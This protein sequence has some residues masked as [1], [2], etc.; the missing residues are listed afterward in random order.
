M[1]NF[2]IHKSTLDHG[3]GRYY[4]T[5]ECSKEERA[6]ISQT[7]LLNS[8]CAQESYFV[9]KVVRYTTQLN[10]ML[11]FRKF[12]PR[13]TLLKLYKAY[14]LLHFYYC[15]SVWHFC[16]ARDAEKL[17]ALN[18]R[19]LKFILGD[20]SSPYSSL[21]TKV[22]STSF[23]NKRIQNFLTLLY[24]SLFFPH[25]LLIWKICFHFGSP[26]MIFEAITFCH[27]VSLEQLAMAL[28]HFPISQPSNGLR[29]Q[30]ISEQVTL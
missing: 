25:F 2:L 23:A 11:C 1:F 21:L 18:K 8:F 6:T 20:Y 13:G 15:S 19:I 28:T 30:T 9:T 14:I 5:N 12:I 3:T 16:G 24:K 17:E 10:V 22:N 26:L 4:L 29:C 7:H 27:S